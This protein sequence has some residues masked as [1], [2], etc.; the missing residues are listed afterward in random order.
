MHRIGWISV[1]KYQLKSYGM[2][3]MRKS[4][5]LCAFRGL[6]V[7]FFFL[8]GTALAQLS[9]V[10]VAL[11]NTAAGVSN[12]HTI[13]FTTTAAL[14]SDGNIVI[15]YPSGFQTGT[16]SIAS[17]TT[18]DGALSVSAAGDSVVVSRSGGSAQTGG[19]TETIR[20]ANI[21]NDT[22]AFNYTVVVRTKDNGSNIIDSGL[23]S[24][25]AV[26]HSTLD[27]FSVSGPGISETAGNAF[28]I[29]INAEDAYDNLV[30]S[31]TSSA[32]LSDLT[33]TL[34]PSQTTSFS[35][36]S[37]SSSNV[38]VTKT[39]TIDNITAQAQGKS[40]TSANFRVDPSGLNVF[41]FN[42]ITSPQTA[43][44]WFGIGITARDTYGNIKTDFS[45]T[46][47]LSEKTATLVV[48][49]T[50]TN[51]TPAFVSGQWNG[52]VQITTTGRDVQITA[53]GSGRSG[54]SGYFNVQPAALDHFAL[55][56]IS[57]QS[58]GTPFLITVIAFDEYENIA[59]QFS[60]TGRRVTIG[61]T[62][63]V[64][65]IS[66]TQSGNFITGFWTG[67]V[68]ISQTQSN[69]RVTVDDGSGHAGT[70][71]SFNIVS[72]SVDHFVISSIGSMQ[73]AGTAFSVTV[74]AVDAS[75]NN[76]TTFNGTASVKD[77][78]GS[79][80]PIQITF[81]NGIWN[82]STTIT[83][84]WSN[85][86]LTVTG[87]GKS[88][89]SNTFQVQSSPVS[90]F[91]ISIIASPKTA[92]NGF[93]I[94]I[95]A[96][97]G[98]G[99]TATGF[100]GTVTI[101]GGTVIVSPAT[102]GVFVNGTRTETV[103]I[104]RALN[105]VQITVRDPA[106]HVGVSNRFNVVHGSLHHF[107]IGSI[108]DQAAGM[109]FAVTVTAQDA[110]NNT[111][112]SFSGAGCTVG[113]SHVGS[114]ITISPTVS[115]NFT[116]GVWIGNVSIAQTQ[117][118]DR[119]NVLRSGG[120]ETGSSNMFAVTPSTVDHFIISPI[121]TNQTAGVGFGVM[122][123]AVDSNNNTVTGF[124]G[125]VNIIDET[126]TNS[127]I[128][129]N[130][131]IG[132][133]SGN[134]TIARSSMSNTLTVTGGGKSGTSN[135]FEVRPAAVDTFEIGL[136]GSPKNAGVGFPITITAKDAFGNTATGFSGTVSIHDA[137]GSISPATSGF[138]NNGVRAET[139]MISHSNQDI[140]ITVDDGSGHSG[141]SNFFNVL[142]GLVHHFSIA[143]VGSQ[144]AGI[145]F[146][147]IIT[148]MDR[149]NSP[150]TAFNGTVD[151]LDLTGSLSPARSG[152]FIAGQWSGG[153]TIDRAMTNNQIS[154]V[155]TG[156]T[157]NGTSNVFTVNAPPGVRVIN[158]SASRTV[159]TA[160]QNQDW[161]LAMAIR[162]LASS[163]A[164]FDSVKVRFR[165]AG[166]EQND[167]QLALPTRL[168]HSQN[169][170]L[171]G[172]Q[173][174]TLAI[175]VDRT[176]RSSGTVT[177]EAVAY[178][179]DEGTG[180]VVKDQ[181]FTGV[182]VQD[183]AELRI[184]R[185]RLSQLEVTEGQNQDW[186]ATVY[187]TNLG[188]S[189]VVVD[190]SQ[191]K[192]YLSFSVG[193]G[194]KYLKP[195]T[196]GNG[197]WTL[198]G[199]E[200]D[201]L[202]LIVDKTGTGK[203][204]IC[205]IN[206]MITAMETN[207]GRTIT[208]DTQ[209]GGKASVL[210]EP[211]VVLRIFSIENLA[212]NDPYVNINQNFTIR[213]TIENIGGDG[214]H[215]VLV[216]LKSDGISISLDPSTKAVESIPG[217]TARTVEFLIQASSAPNDDELFSIT[218]TGYA[219]NNPEDANLEK[220]GTLHVVI[221]NPA[222]LY[223][224]RV[225][226]SATKLIGGQKDPWTVK[227]AVRNLGEA[228]LV[229]DSPKADD[230]SFWNSDI[231]QVDYTV[232]PPAGFMRGGLILPGGEMDTLVYTITTT[233]S[234]GGN[235]QIKAK[236]NAK[237]INSQLGITGEGSS[238]VYVQSV[239][240][241]RIISTQIETLNK[242]KDG[243]GY[244]NIQQEF[245]VLVIVE[246][247]LGQSVN[248]IQIKL[249]TNGH[250]E[251]LN[252]SYPIDLLKPSQMDSTYFRIRADQKENPSEILS[253]RI[254]Q[255]NFETS[256]L[257]V[258][259]GTSLDS[260]AQVIVQLPAVLAL[261]LEM[262]N[263]DGLVSTSQN[264]TVQATLH[265]LG[266][267]EIDSP[268]SVQLILPTGYSLRSASDTLRV[269]LDNPA[270]WTIQAPESEHS[271]DSIFV[272]LNSVPNDKNTGAQADV[273][274]RTAILR[275]TTVSSQIVTMLSIDYPPGAKDNVLSTGQSF[276]LK[277]KIDSRNVI[278]VTAKIQ[279]PLGYKTKDDTVK[280]VRSSEAIWQIE[281]PSVPAAQAS[282]QV[283][284]Q[285]ED[286]LQQDKAVTGKVSLFSVATVWRVELELDLAIIEP[287]DVAQNKTVSLG[288]EFK[289]EARVKKLG[290]A[291]T[292]GVTK[293]NLE[294]LPEG[295][296]TLEP[297]TKTC[298]NGAAAWWI[299]APMQ[300]S[301]EA[302]NIN[303]KLTTLPFD[304]N[305]NKEAFVR[306]SNGS[307][308]VTMAGAWLAAMPVDLP[309]WVG[310]TVIPG[311]TWVRLMAFEVDNRGTEGTKRIILESLK[312]QVEDRF[313]NPISPQKAL[314]EITI[315][316]YQDSTKKYG[317][318]SEL[319]EE[320]P[321]TVVFT[322]EPNISP[323][324]KK[325]LAVFGRIAK[326]PEI[327]YFQLN[328]PAVDYMN[329]KDADSRNNVPVKNEAGEEWT[330]F[331][332][333]PKK[334]FKTEAESVLWNC[335]NPFSPDKE[336]TKITYFLENNSDVTFSLYTLIGER[337]W[338][339][340]FKAGESN[341]SAGI[342]T[343]LWDGRNGRQRQVLNGV[344]LLFMKTAD[345]KVVKTKIAIVK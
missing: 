23:S 130:F 110:N 325:K 6:F 145:P 14:P 186:T 133:W 141:K 125:N 131:S 283:Q 29:T 118:S 112:T 47:T 113:I 87:V 8:A 199:G 50:G 330:E 9:S 249:N 54:T 213:A 57:D 32:D 284:V 40:G 163:N 132:Q 214:L 220:E 31:F 46:V 206:A 127:P 194:W 152:S 259:I 95:T 178:F 227:V 123:R 92:G 45:G 159:A 44:A 154:V 81:T 84:S 157:E 317:T 170:V 208:I 271:I 255:A 177:V 223:V 298:V 94:N 171:A 240:A 205:E 147:V 289:I 103:T 233:G 238:S 156:G 67:N 91:E 272:T 184:E 287:L 320:N 151:M 51:L 207:T 327:D 182:V 260:V 242:T 72:S 181:G 254:V 256:G 60:G 160:A 75:S 334:I 262:S 27:H 65:T 288:Q 201:S 168:N 193:T 135:S 149:F 165:L 17:S 37:W 192:T 28:T 322:L 5:S 21:T 41:E 104:T 71:N 345:G 309:F 215:S 226:T 230:L 49:S 53:T 339:V 248:A 251:I 303:T 247:G 336:P 73:T 185:I 161:M 101:D 300:Q 196:L 318:T 331:R 252:Q 211:P 82:G 122:I 172:N 313:G 86:F 276:I 97:D 236:I 142:P 93:P 292:V 139:V 33:G 56:T 195:Q 83:K 296:T 310:S 266:S 315:T 277:A 34:S 175:L 267:A 43:G 88:G 311:Q 66:P 253:A 150:A 337:I 106:A 7:I 301:A 291:D 197:S 76:V 164:H 324:E 299:K 19:E 108:A 189:T 319:F 38:I 155:R 294:A 119:I 129:I 100:S 333:N 307:V 270:E 263:P 25:F 308:P 305:T 116:N 218:V 173:Q 36:G 328:I 314:A 11:G 343:I 304:E 174:D 166:I 222:D 2:F 258:S 204:G 225:A 128:T 183:S 335:P 35:A 146:T 26:T 280:N 241:F 341:G 234:L 180:S 250:S 191:V 158:F 229:L 340:S 216:E 20:L 1:G 219:D 24:S 143:T 120:S 188:G 74:R 99:N 55:V 202:S 18:M 179:T 246:N 297:Y 243:N 80:S 107:A 232:N 15:V 302:V 244:V 39:A 200:T 268:A 52:N 48:Q 153:V 114:E 293:V 167:Y 332:S 275:V 224:Q 257:P 312:L 274:E 109:P 187:I 30:T 290:D 285:G 264:F 228:A 210:I 286:S 98:F 323:N 10:T 121:G 42:S 59:T 221:Q 209:N 138:F 176:G 321:V 61:H 344:Y 126:G 89:T 85:D 190:S 90:N 134:V 278:N 70:S 245:Q 148:A 68:S 111:V 96:K 235:V 239:R 64:G 342:H 22:V 102:S 203:I 237:D 295:Y 136:I 12:I 282:I 212:P 124:S 231:Y 198:R 269:E 329:A 77:E 169:R 279:L 140:T 78:S 115:G 16:A 105:D 13:T 273:D 137:S 79:I 217:G 316:D 306:K 117:A 261:S 58:A 326:N 62:G 3:Y 144:V 338:A 265:N 4:F 63:V 69:D 281:A 162:N